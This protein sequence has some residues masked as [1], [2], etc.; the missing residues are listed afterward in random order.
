MGVPNR[1]KIVLKGSTKTVTEFFGFAVN[2]CGHPAITP[3]PLLDLR[4]SR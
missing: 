4:G 3:L 1:K 2:W